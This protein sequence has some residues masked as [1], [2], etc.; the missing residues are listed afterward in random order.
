M[1][2]IP[3]RV[4]PPHRGTHIRAGL[5]M[6][7]RP[8]LRRQ[9]LAAYLLIAPAV[10]LFTVFTFIPMVETFTMS[11]TD[12]SLVSASTHWVGWAN[13]RA[14]LGSATFR[15]AFFNTAIFAIQVLPLNIACSLGLATLVY[16]KFRGV[17]WFRTIFFA[18]VVTSM[19]AVSIIWTWLFDPSNGLVNELLALFHLPPQAW[20]VEPH[21]A[22]EVLVL[23]RVWKGI[24]ANMVI[25]LAGLNA[26]PREFWEASV[27]D[28]A[29]RAR[30]FW[31][32]TWPLLR[33][34][35]F[36]V[37]VLGTISLFQAFSEMYV[38]TQG[39]PMGT[40]TTVVYLVFNVAF[41]EFRLG[42]GAAIAAI[43]FVVI[44][45][46]SLVNLLVVQ[47]RMR[48]DY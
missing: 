19:V 34:T 35:T 3:P 45:T 31:T 4:G 15:Q 21:W 28:G 44:L 48:I 7:M 42:Y 43:L 24:G 47:R 27:V 22:L 32:I 38:M 25:F 10:V 29:D 1:A 18:P 14:I 5:E 16:G 11:F 13:Y 12:K 37:L 2:A 6:W 8:H 46:L 33:P 39:G 23:L 20:L 17:G 30:R 26:I 36:Y 9:A 41:Q 40:T